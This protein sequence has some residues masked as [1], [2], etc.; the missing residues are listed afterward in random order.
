LRLPQTGV[1]TM[2]GNRMVNM[3]REGVAPDFLVEQHPDQLAKGE[4]PQ[5]AK[6]VEVLRADVAAWKKKKSEELAKKDGVTST[7][8]GTGTDPMSKPM[9]KPMVD[10]MKR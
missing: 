1:Y 10:P 6:A 9:A 4:D 5:L 2:R 8:P 3:E 7:N